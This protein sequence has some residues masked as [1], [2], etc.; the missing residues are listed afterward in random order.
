[1]YPAG[2]PSGIVD[3]TN[4]ALKD[5]LARPEIKEQLEKAGASAH[6]STPAEFGKHIADEV[7]KW[8]AVRDKA[9]LTP[10]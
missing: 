2:T 6:V 9:G 3:K 8:H 5:I 10:Q 7:A 1:V 4:A